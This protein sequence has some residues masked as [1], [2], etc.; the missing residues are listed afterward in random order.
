MASGGVYIAGGIAPK[1]I[2]R[3]TA[4]AFMRAFL[5]KGRLSPFLTTIPV[6][7]VMNPKVGLMGAALVASRLQ[8]SL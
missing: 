4:G 2:D 8:N 6:Q 3:L 5:N 1:I 7:V